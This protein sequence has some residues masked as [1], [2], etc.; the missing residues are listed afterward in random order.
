MPAGSRRTVVIGI[1]VAVDVYTLHL[2]EYDA[3]KHLLQIVVLIG[4]G[5]IGP[6]LG[7]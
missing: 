7:S 3:T 1:G 5:D 6:H 4:K 2:S